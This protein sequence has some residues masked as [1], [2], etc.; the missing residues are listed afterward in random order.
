M[1]K[2]NVGRQPTGQTSRGFPAQNSTNPKNNSTR[3]P[4]RIGSVPGEGGAALLND[5]DNDGFSDGFPSTQS[6]NMF[7]RGNPSA[8]P[9]DATVNRGYSE[10]TGANVPQVTS[11]SSANRSLRGI[12]PGT[13]PQ[14]DGDTTKGPNL[15]RY[16]VGTNGE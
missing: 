16:G 5:A 2:R 12:D 9:S 13:P 11:V 10:V 14:P 15:P 7:G 1:D 3:R 6:Q 4:E 8:I